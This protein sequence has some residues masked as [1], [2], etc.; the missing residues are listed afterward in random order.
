[1][2]YA[3]AY[4]FRITTRYQIGLSKWSY[5]Y[6]LLSQSKLLSAHIITTILKQSTRTII[7]VKILL[8]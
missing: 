6:K 7:L 1:M 2:L 3:D 4:I 5:K 8:G